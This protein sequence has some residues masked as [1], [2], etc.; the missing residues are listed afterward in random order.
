M[1]PS[2]AANLTKQAAAREETAQLARKEGGL[3]S[4]A[5]QV[6]AGQTESGDEGNKSKIPKGLKVA[7]PILLI[8]GAF[9]GII[10]LIIGLPIMMIGAIDYNLQKALGFT[11][12]VGVLEKQGEYVTA[13]MAMN[14]EVPAKYASDLAEHGIDVGQVTANG[15]FYKTNVYIA[16]IEEK[17]GLVAAAS[18]FSYVSSEEGELA[19]LY[20]GEVIKA[21]DFVAKVESD[22]KLYAAY[23]GAADLSARYYY[24]TDAT[25]AFNDMGLSRGVFNGVETTGDYKL[26]EANFVSTL[27]AF[28]DSD[29]ELGVGGRLDDKEQPEQAGILPWWHLDEFNDEGK[30]GGNWNEEAVDTEIS[31]TTAE[32]TMAYIDGWGINEYR[33]CD[34]DE[35]GVEIAGTCKNVKRWGPSFTS[36]EETT[37]RA[38][39]LLNSAASS[40]EPYQAAKVFMA[41]EEPI[42]RAR[43]GDNGPVN[44]LMNVIS[45]PST[46]SY[47]NVQ[48]G[49]METKTTSILESTNFK[50]AVGESAYSAEEAANFA[51]DRALIMTGYT[52]SSDMEDTIEKNVVSSDGQGY[53]TSS[54]RNGK[55]WFFMTDEECEEKRADADVVSGLDQTLTEVIVEENSSKFQSV[56]GANRVLQGGSFISN[57]INQRAI[58]AMPSDS[59]AIAQ[60][61][62][63]VEE[64]LARKAEA[65]R[66]SLSPFDIS[67]PNTFLGSIVH[68]L[69]TIA[70]KNYS[71]SGGVSLTGVATGM[72]NNAISSLTSS[73]TAEGANYKFTTMIGTNCDTVN[74]VST[75]GDLY[76]S[77]RNTNNTDYMNYTLDDWKGTIVGGSID[78]EGRILDGSALEQYVTMGMDRP[79]TVGVKS[80]EV[81]K[82]YGDYS[83]KSG[84][85]KLFSSF[86]EV[87]S[88]Y[89]ACKG[90]DDSFATGAVFTRG[91]EGGAEASEG[92]V[93]CEEEGESSGPITWIGDSISNMDRDEITALLPEAEI[94]AEDGKTIQLDYGGNKAALNILKDKAGSIHDYV[95]IQIGTNNYVDDRDPDT[96]NQGWLT[97]GQLDELAS[98]LAGKT[99]VIVTNYEGSNPSRFD[100]NN[101]LIRAAASKYGWTVADWASVATSGDVDDGSSHHLGFR[102]HL[103]NTGKTKFA[104]TIASALKQ[105]G[106]KTGKGGCSGG[107]N[108]EIDVELFSAYMLYS[109]VHALLS[110]GDSSVALVRQ[111]YYAEHPKDN[112]EAGVIARISGMTKYEAEVALAYSDYLNE[113]ARYDSSDRY[114]FGLG[115][116]GQVS[117]KSKLEIHSEKMAGDYV[118]WYTKEHEFSDLR[119]RNFVV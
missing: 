36:K 90:V 56:V 43:I 26:D 109:Q 7:A 49:E 68:N 16:N 5:R 50:A 86:L 12:T 71:Y 32:N 19:M 118:A 61:D 110:D 28:L 116:I 45:K 29:S 91:P 98:Y 66:A 44:A 18:G 1:N 78:D 47:Q 96:K 67:S 70:L 34:T 63:V 10:A 51:K 55:C 33:E 84:W 59:A 58:G 24:S 107:S 115:V 92:E 11:E 88:M 53:S 87:M 17:E 62:K 38:V 40:S 79:T 81:C 13:E 103:T 101:A 60:Y 82:K 80:A 65:D 46:V 4:G 54:S 106:Y 72:T 105:A 73:A 23:S 113:I 104:K 6:E 111:R 64:T 14:G 108:G 22:P 9:F 77:S 37:R 83:Q 52:G 114:Q 76:C 94:E 117:D 102:V 69:A 48:T 30:G 112:S 3:Y 100:G 39:E 97:E 41:I 21:C 89:D 95:V 27:N 2:T 75:E 20:N 25:E 57:T 42:Q 85:A 31:G 74:A 93:T 8:L 15:D 99:V 35:N 119:T